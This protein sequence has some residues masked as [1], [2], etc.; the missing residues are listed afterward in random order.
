MIPPELEGPG[1][2]VFRDPAGVPHVQ[3]DTVECLAEGHGAVT[4]VDRIWD[5][6]V[7]RRRAEGRSAYL[8][9]AEH[10]DGDHLSLSLGV[11]ETA[12]RWWNAAAPQDQEFLAAYARGVNRF[13][14]NAWRSS[15]PVTDLGVQDNV[16]APWEPWTPVA[17]HLEIHALAGSLPE[18]LW[19]RRVHEVLGEDWNRVLDAESPRSAASN[20]WLVPEH[21]S[22]S[23]APM[24]AADPHRVIEESGP[25]QPVCFS[26]P[27]LRIRGLALV[28]LPGVPHFGRTE[29]AAWA[30]TASMTTTETV[31]TVVVERR[32]A[33][34]IE[35][36]TGTPLTQRRVT[37]AGANGSSDERWIRT[38]DGAAVLPG[39][40][41][42]EERVRD[43]PEGQRMELTVVKPAQDRA[44]AGAMTAT[45]TLLSAMTTDDVVEAL[46]GWVLPVNDVVAADSNGSC[47]H[48][49]A[50][51]H[52]GAPE[53]PT[54][55]AELTIRANQRPADPAQSAARL[56]CA[57]PHRAD[58]ARELLT[59][60]LDHQS[61]DGPGRIGHDDLLAA[62]L[63]TL[64]PH[65]PPLLRDLLDDDAAV[66]EPLSDPARA[67]RERLL[68]WD[69]SMAA[70]S[71]DAATFAAW[72]DEFAR[73]LADSEPLRALGESTGLP[74]LWTPFLD[75][76]ARVGLA[77]E[78]IVRHGTS[79]GLDPRRAAAEALDSVAARI[80]AAR[81]APEVT[82]GRA[83]RFAPWRAHSAL[84]PFPTVDLGGDTDCLL[85]AGTLPGK[86]T[87]CVRVPAARVL[88]DLADPAASLW[89]TPDPVDRGS[90]GT[91]PL[92]SWARGEVDQA[93]PWVPPG[94]AG[95]TDRRLPLGDAA[96]HL[97]Q[98]SLPP[99]TTLPVALRPLDPVADLSTVHEWVR[100]P[101]ARFWG[102]TELSAEE[103]GAI[104]ALIRFSPT[105]DAWII[106]ADGQPIGIFQTYQP[107]GDAAG[108]MFRVEPGDLGMHLLLADTAQ[109]IHGLTGALSVM[110]ARQ[111]LSAG[112]RRVVVEPDVS[113]H[114]ALRRMQ[115]LG[116]ELGPEIQ[117]PG[118][119]GRLAFYT[120][121]PDA[122]S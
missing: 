17:A 103:V 97:P 56:G 13:A 85:A 111:V 65:W 79:V 83:H 114:L 1:W 73:V 24:I 19:R 99:G 115:A 58:R 64:L 6:E 92:D 98:G 91:T 88:W 102:M 108:A 118:K 48:L 104:Y 80:V 94:S 77:L 28:G 66:S 22:A 93:L 30:I 62:Q 119:T 74:E 49:V 10:S 4:A 70:E 23:G 34:L 3:A 120:P 60:A 67:L 105:H 78:S 50:G 44:P 32:S 27:G 89:I 51:Q 16:P 61:E 68:A 90:L 113:N 15:Q 55:V 39:D 43:L 35:V 87:G 9:G 12:R 47:V 95:P 53:P 107:H 26:A 71:R 57:P 101:R 112:T 116:F 8:L 86:G 18:Q 96:A 31:R 75:P 5:L 37:V 84:P 14:E 117:L 41:S 121:E 63:D 20:A 122:D 106:E 42:F 38:L 46:A 36:T 76:T 82:W 45:R 81:E 29:G 109:R 21:L 11:A 40:G 69:G 33:E 52:A 7:L 100:R 54:A 59:A 2:R 72:R 110:L 25:Y